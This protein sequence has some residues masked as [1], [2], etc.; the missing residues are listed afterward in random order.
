MNTDRISHLI[1]MILI[2]PILA[3]GQSNVYE[4]MN[5]SL[6]RS[7]EPLILNKARF[8]TSVGLIE[9]LPDGVW[10]YYRVKKFTRRENRNNTLLYE[11]TYRDSLKNGRFI[12]YHYLSRGTKTSVPFVV[13]N[14]KNGVLHGPFVVYHSSG[15]KGEDGNFKDGKKH[16]LFISYWKTRSANFIE[17]VELYDEDILIYSCKYFPNAGVQEQEFMKH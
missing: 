4:I 12:I 17:D 8:G 10:K 3:S 14:Y 2:I 13:L 6:F 15:E 16:G 9:R 11:G 7:N 1:Y 5:D